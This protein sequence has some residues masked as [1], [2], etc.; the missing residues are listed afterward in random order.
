MRRTCQKGGRRAQETNKQIALTSMPSWS[1]WISPA[2]RGPLAT[3]SARP[4]GNAV[5][6][7]LPSE[8]AQ[9][10]KQATSS[11]ILLFEASW[12]DGPPPF[13]AFESENHCCFRNLGNVLAWRRLAYSAV[14]RLLPIRSPWRLQ[15]KRLSSAPLLAAVGEL[16][17]TLRPELLVGPLQI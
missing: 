10:Q 8:T 13:P 5:N 14:R 9:V 2:H 1:H 4:H 15:H 17:Q 3:P 11:L 16:L 7:F 6:P 12:M